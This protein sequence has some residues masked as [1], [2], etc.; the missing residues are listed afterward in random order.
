MVMRTRWAKS[1]AGSV[2][3]VELCLVGFANAAGM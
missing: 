2:G 1:I 3:R